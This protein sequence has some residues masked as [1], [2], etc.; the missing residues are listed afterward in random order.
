MK[1]TVIIRP[2]IMVNDPDPNPS[3]DDL[4]SLWFWDEDEDTLPEINLDLL[5]LASPK[6]EIEVVEEEKDPFDLLKKLS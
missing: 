1:D 5:P 6:R 2:I 3:L 4:D